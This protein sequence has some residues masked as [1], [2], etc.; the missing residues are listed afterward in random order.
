VNAA[1]MLYKTAE[2]GLAVD[3]ADLAGLDVAVFSADRHY[4]YALTRIWELRDHEGQPARMAVWVMLNPSR[5]DA[6]HNDQT[7]TRCVAF[8]RREGCG[9]LIVV[10]LFAVRSPHPT[11]MKSHPHPVGAHN[12]RVLELVV[13]RLP[14]ALWI[15]AWGDHGTHRG[16]GAEVASRLAAA[17]IQL[18]C[19]GV[20]ESGQPRHPVRLAANTLLGRYDAAAKGATGAGA[21]GAARWARGASRR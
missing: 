15:A 1:A 7:L 11:I 3:Q 13:D 14:G 20:T 18:H 8:T 9:G 19:L 16:R 6:L 17:G 10:N 21:E 2:W 4:R 12:D 5:A